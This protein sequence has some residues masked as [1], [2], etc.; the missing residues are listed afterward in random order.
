MHSRVTR[1][2]VSRRGFSLIELLVVISIIA[3]LIALLLPALTRVRETANRSVC[4]SNLRQVATSVHLY[5]ADHDDH[6]PYGDTNEPNALDDL[7]P[8][9]KLIRMGYTNSVDTTNANRD[10]RN[11]VFFCPSNPN[12]EFQPGT[13]QNLFQRSGYY[14]RGTG[15]P[16]HWLDSGGN[17]RPDDA[18]FFKIEDFVGSG[19]LTEFEVWLKNPDNSHIAPPHDGE[20]LAIADADASGRLYQTRDQVYRSGWNAQTIDGLFRSYFDVR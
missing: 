11:P 17:P 1:R 13:A 6:I 18:R 5:A 8:F 4:M 10:E 12:P 7:R 19:M 16:W 3:V 14:L 15:Q 9:G 2:A 20:V